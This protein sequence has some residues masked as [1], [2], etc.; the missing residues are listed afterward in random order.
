M[1]NCFVGAPVKC[2]LVSSARFLIAKDRL[3]KRRF[4]EMTDGFSKMLIFGKLQP[5]CAKGILL[6]REFTLQ[7]H[8]GYNVL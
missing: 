6:K 2:V 7:F 4:K 3:S 8:T 1:G 5:E